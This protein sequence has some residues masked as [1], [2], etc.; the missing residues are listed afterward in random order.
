V[1]VF[2]D[3]DVDANAKTYLLA[4][5]SSCFFGDRFDVWAGR[6]VVRCGRVEYCMTLNVEETCLVFSAGRQR[7]GWLGGCLVGPTWATL[8]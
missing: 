3:V 5:V 8:H 6:G 7:I 4:H 1:V 2:R